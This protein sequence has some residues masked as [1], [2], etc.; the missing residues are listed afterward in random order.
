MSLRR[1][2]IQ[3]LLRSTAQS[4]RYSSTMVKVNHKQAALDFLSFVNAS[5]TRKKTSLSDRHHLTHCSLPCCQVQQRPSCSCRISRDQ[6]ASINKKTETLIQA[7]TDC[8]QE[9]DS[10]NSTLHPGGKYY[11]TRNTSTLV[12]FAIGKKW[13][14]RNC[15]LP[16][17]L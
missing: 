7:P 11:L 13:Q 1:T 6:S 16:T 17:L 5:P 14:V 9:R 15:T 2:L 12:A 10:W 8:D 4:Y 3:S